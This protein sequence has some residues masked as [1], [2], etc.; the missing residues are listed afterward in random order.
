MGTAAVNVLF[1]TYSYLP[2]LGG[3]ERSVHNLAGLLRAHGHDVAVATHDLRAVP[4]RYRPRDSPPTL[5]LHIPSQTDPRRRVRVFRALINP[6]NVAILAAICRRRRIAVVHGHHLNTDTVYARHL[7]RLLGVRFVLTL[8]GGETEEWITTPARRQYVIEQ[9]RSADAVTAVSASLLA[10]A[11]ELVPEIVTR[12]AVI[13]N[14]ID[15]AGVRADVEAITDPEDAGRAPYFL[16]AGRLEAMKDVA[17]LIDAYE[18]TLTA[19]PAFPVDLVVAGAG[20]LRASLEARAR[21]GA[22]AGRVRFLG[23]LAHPRVLRLIAGARAVVLPSR[24]SE[25]CPNVV[26]EA[27]AL[28]TPVIVSDLASH[29]E[30]VENGASGLMF[31]AGDAA[32][33]ARHLRALATTAALSAGLAAAA[34][35]HI[36]TRHDGA[37]IAARYA[38]IYE[39]AGAA[40]R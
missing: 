20:S 24:C 30:I 34:D 32:A 12:A 25:G 16:F 21:G 15:P 10:Q 39:R 13:P 6:L 26:L 29:A 18:R 36:R 33:L 9:L 40:D 7:A 38:A 5:H 1:L 11:T 22:A 35:R 2:N 28:G 14:P 19:A 17:C 4:F 3:V 23:R 27:M 31:P 8:R 37:D